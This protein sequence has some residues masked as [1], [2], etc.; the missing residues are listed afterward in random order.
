ML[1]I[2]V[3]Q[4]QTVATLKRIAT[5]IFQ[6]GG[7]IRKIDNLGEN[8]TPYKMSAHNR[9]HRK[10]SYFILHF[11]APPRKLEDFLEECHRDIDLV[12]TRVFKV[13][14]EKSRACTWHEEML[15]P[16]DRYVY[17]LSDLFYF[18]RF[19]MVHNRIQL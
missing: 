17:Q 2:V 19:D 3:I 9:V 5:G 15:P 1:I 18:I 12:R 4:P 14:E 8:P 10:V 13:D 7:V 11:D 6:R 16:A